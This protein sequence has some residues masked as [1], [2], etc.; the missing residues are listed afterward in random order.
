MIHRSVPLVGVCSPMNRPVHTGRGHHEAEGLSRC[1]I[2]WLCASRFTRPPFEASSSSST[3]TSPC[4]FLELSFTPPPPRVP[5][6]VVLEVQFR[7]V[8]LSLCLHSLLLLSAP[9]L[10]DEHSQSPP[11]RWSASATSVTELDS[12]KEIIKKS[13]LS[14]YS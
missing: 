6:T 3:V 12:T 8:W 7:R 2:Y 4:R 1:T 5:V 11:C 13:I 14:Q 10:A 9:E